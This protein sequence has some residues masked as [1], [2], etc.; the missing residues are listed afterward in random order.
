MVFMKIA[1]PYG[2][3]LI[4]AEVPDR[5]IAVSYS[6]KKEKPVKNAEVEERV[7]L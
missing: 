6:S 5:N 4:E 7:K 3:D 1:L 2:K